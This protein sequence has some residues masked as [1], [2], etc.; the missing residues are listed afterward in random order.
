MK[1]TLL[2][3]RFYL[4]LLLPCPAAI[5]SD[6]SQLQN[7]VLQAFQSMLPNIRNHYAYA[8]YKKP[9]WA[10]LNSNYS[11]QINNLNNKVDAV[12]FFER[13]LLEFADSH[14]TLNTNTNDSYRLSSPVVVTQHHGNQRFVIDDVWQNQLINPTELII[15]AELTHIND[16]TINEVIVNFPTLCLDKTNTNNQQWI[17]NKTLAGQYSKPRTITIKLND[18]PKNIDLDALQYK[19]T[20]GPLSSRVIDDFAVIEINNS[21]GQTELIHAFDQRLNQLNET[22]GLILDLRNTISGGDTYI[23][24][25][26]IGRFIEHDQAYQ[27]HRFAEQRKGG[28]KVTRYW[29]EYVTPRLPTYKK[30]LVVLV[31]RWTGSMGEGLTIGLHGMQRAHVMGTPMAGLLGAVYGFQLEGLGFGYQMPAEQLFHVDGTPRESFLPDTLTHSN[32]EQPDAV[33]NQALAWLK[34]QP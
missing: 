27:K 17:I 25:A 4:L 22:R 5:A 30:P 8:E 7:K 32:S 11:Q 23:A 10:C 2:K 14:M 3:Y 21:L 20:N 12:L 18:K 13:L 6:Q 15:G 24:R 34:N 26:L 9:D 31:N 28:P 1:N 33:L 19:Q 16:A 29:T